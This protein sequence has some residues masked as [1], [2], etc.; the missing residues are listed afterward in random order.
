MFQEVI[1]LGAWRRGRWVSLDVTKRT[2]HAAAV[3]YIGTVIELT[4]IKSLARF[5][6]K[7][8]PRASATRGPDAR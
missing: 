3:M 7:A 8:F 1:R 4:S 2:V 6:C 5:Q